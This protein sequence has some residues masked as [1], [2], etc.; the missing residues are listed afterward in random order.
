VKPLRYHPAVQRDLD[1][2]MA[3]YLSIS[4]EVAGGFWAEICAA[5]EQIREYPERGH[6]DPSGL[7]RLN[8]KR[9]PFHIL[10]LVL[11]DR[12]RV[13]VVRSNSRRPSFGARRKAPRQ[14]AP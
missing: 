4:E 8:L 1:G 2:A 14:E 3:Y 11:P 6:F 13:Q 12:L 7:R 9:F 10:C 5:F